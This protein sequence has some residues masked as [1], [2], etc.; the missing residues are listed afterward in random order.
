[1]S[2]KQKPTCV[3]NMPFFYV[4]RVLTALTSLAL[5]FLFMYINFKQNF[6]QYIINWASQLIL[7]LTKYHKLT[8]SGS[9]VAY[10]FK[11]VY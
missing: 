10:A 11:Y 6:S 8:N 5:P 9:D 4:I 1:M 3:S 2:N 7:E